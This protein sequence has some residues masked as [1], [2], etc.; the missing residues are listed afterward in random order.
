M[1]AVL[2]I[3]ILE[4]NPSDVC[5]LEYELNKA[6]FNF[7]SYNARNREEFEKALF[8]FKP[9]II[10]SDY[11]LPSFNGTQAFII[12]QKI[13]PHVP[14]I[15]VSGTIGD[16]NAVELIKSGVTDYILKGRLM[17]LPQKISRAL[18]DL[19]KAEEK[20]I[21]DKN[22]YK[23]KNLYAF[24]SQVNQNIV[25]VKDETTLF[26]NSCHLAT[27][28]GKFKMSWVGLFDF[29]KKTIS[30]VEQYGIPDE[31]L[32]LFSN[33]AYQT[34]DV[35]DHILR[36]GTYFVSNDIKNDP[37]LEN[38]KVYALKRNLNSCIV[39]PIKKSGTIIGTFNL[40]STEH[41]FSGADEVKLLEEVTNDI[42]FAL[43]IFEKDRKQRETD[44]K[45]VKNE[46]RRVFDK[47][48]LNALINNTQDLMW[49]V[50][51]SYNLITA[52]KPFDEMAKDTF[53]KIVEKGSSVLSVG[54]TAKVLEEFKNSYDRTFSGEMFTEVKYFAKPLEL[55]SE[56]SYS[57]I[58]KENKIIGAAC[59]SRNITERKKTEIERE[60]MLANI[61]QH[62][63]NLEQFA[64]IVSHNLRAPVA[65]I[66]GIANLLKSNISIEDRERSQNFLFGATEQLDLIIKD[67]NNILQVRSEI[68]EF[69]EVVYFDELIGSIKSGIHHAV[70]KETI[71][72]KAD[73]TAIE[74]ITS[75]KSY[76][77]SVFYNLISNS[78][79]Y[80]KPGSIPE[81]TIETK[82]IDNKIVITFTDNGLGID[83]V[84]HGDKIFGLYKRFHLNT[85]GKGLGLF[86][87]KTQIETLGGQISIQSKEG[88]GA[89]FIIELPLSS[90]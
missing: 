66:L 14:F 18:K 23:A 31:D 58:R 30:L 21:T 72:I 80:R 45:I 38:F 28:F 24:I 60:K 7:S 36:S 69:K 17:A 57:P 16:E 2:K 22:L 71:K 88:E 46:K 35:E 47:N 74:K 55:W 42:S 12:K 84:K 11:S 10:L 62:S 32:G 39:L 20:L 53:G 41:N 78:I 56:I 27:D 65:N 68:N 85:E 77:H 81:I 51:S 48:N 13:S 89:R 52:N 44:K 67:L 76:I 1:E 61:V 6:E 59:F 70:E 29:D 82:I 8:N 75:I 43:D 19:E 86:M 50:D 54:Y 49:S 4:D 87:V 33:Y 40:Y 3:L 37:K 15:I 5:L 9:D 64:Q 90:H 26:L 34:S 83:L 73:F 79:K 63:R 25:R